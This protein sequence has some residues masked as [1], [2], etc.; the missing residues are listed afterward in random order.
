MTRNDPSRLNVQQTL[1]GAW[2]DS[3]GAGVPTIQISGHT[4]WR[5]TFG[6]GD[7]GTRFQELYDQVYLQWHERRAAAI[8]SGIDPDLV[9]LVFADALDDFTVVVAPMNFTLRRSRSRPL[10]YQYQINLTVVGEDVD[11]GLLGGLGGLLDGGIL[12]SVGLESLIQSVNRITQ[13][14]NDVQ[15]W[16]DRN[17]VAPVKSFMNQTARLY[18]AVRGAIAAIDGVAGSLIS[19]AQMT[20]QAGINLFRTFAAVASIPSLAKARLMQIAG[21]YTNIW[22]VLWNALRQQIYYPDY[23]PLFGASNC[24]STSGGRPISVLSGE[25]PFYSVVPTR[26]PLPVTLTEPAQSSLRVLASNDPV[27]A[28][29]STAEISNAVINVAEGMAVAA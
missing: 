4:G 28:P 16:I 9:K 2:A 18:G 14:I 22:C 19:I 10:L 25:N 21:A 1:G 8:Q 20:A 11:G 26:A 12:E 24:S 3:F 29:L 13:A 23:S 6:S 27:L 7:G 5:P 15:R 17:L